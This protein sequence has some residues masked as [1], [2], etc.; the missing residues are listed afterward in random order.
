MK[1]ALVNGRWNLWL[2]DG[3]A[4]WDAITGDYSARQGWEFRRFQS[5]Q[6]HLCYGMCLYD[7]GVEHGWISAIYGREFV[8]TENMVLFEPS[9]EFWINI[10]K[11]WRYNGLDD[12]IGAL[13]AFVGAKTSDADWLGRTVAGN[14]W[15][16]CADSEKPETEAMPYRSLLHHTSMI[17]TVALDDLVVLG[18]RPPDA[19]TID[20]EGAELS[21]LMGMDMILREVRPQV[22]ISVHPDLMQ[23]FGDT[24]DELH[25]FMNARGYDGEFLGRDHENHW[26]FRP[27]ALRKR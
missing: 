21:V 20:V 26:Y 15:P 2:P 3:I 18:V 6:R 11:I 24:E 23:D 16:S 22:W 1:Q 19:V 25:T 27:I 8:G 14:A 10:R 5:M 17:N 7:V 12:P 9:E 4:D 13:Q